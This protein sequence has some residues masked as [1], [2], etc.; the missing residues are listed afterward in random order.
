MTMNVLP[1]FDLLFNNNSNVH[2]SSKVQVKKSPRSRVKMHGTLTIP[3]K[4][5][6]YTMCVQAAYST[7]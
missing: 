1:I 6:S 5:P 4:E 2:L 7:A 3:D